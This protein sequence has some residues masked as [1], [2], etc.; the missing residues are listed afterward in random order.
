VYPFLTIP[1]ELTIEIFFH[2]LPYKFTQ[3][4]PSV[5]PM[6]LGTVCRQWREIAWNIPALW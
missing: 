2:C 5:A 3:P 6:L 4:S 1:T